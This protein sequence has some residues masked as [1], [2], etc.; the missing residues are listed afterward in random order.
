MMQQVSST[1]FLVFALM[2][3]TRGEL[4]FSTEIMDCDIIFTWTGAST[5]I[6]EVFINQYDGKQDWIII[7]NSSIRVK[8]ALLYTSIIMSV[9]VYKGKL[10]DS[11][12]NDNTLNYNVQPVQPVIKGNIDI[13]VGTNSKLTCFVPACLSREASLSY[14]W[15]INDTKMKEETTEMLTFPVTRDHKYNQYSCK[16]ANNGVESNRSNPVTINTLCELQFS[17]EIMDCDIIFTWT[18]A[19]TN[20]TEVFIN[21]YDGKQDWIIINNSSI[22]VKNALLY[23]SIIMSVRVYK[24]KLRDSSFN[25]N[26][27]NYNVQPVQPVIKGNIDILVGTNS[28]LTCFVPAC[29]SREASLSYTWFINDTKMKEETTE[30]LTF[31][32]TRDHKYNQYSC[33]V[34]NNGVES[35]RSN[36]VTI[37][38]LSNL[39]SEIVTPFLNEN[40]ILMGASIISGILVMTLATVAG[41]YFIKRGRR[42]KN[43]ESVKVE[44]VVDESLHP[45]HPTSALYATIDRKS[46]KKNYNIDETVNTEKDVNVK[47]ESQLPFTSFGKEEREKKDS[48]ENEEGNAIPSAKTDEKSVSSNLKQEGLIYIEVDFANKPGSTD[49]NVQPM[50][51]GQEDPTEYTFVDFSQKAPPEQDKPENVEQK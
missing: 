36:P 45:E 32:V 12:F 35:N 4:Q 6:T 49:T 38:T 20:I 14:T 17:T 31:P 22:R 3:T 44:A 16:V 42:E 41:L 26:T 50:I 30:M 2:C 47:D 39:K 19:S 37:N 9:R 13:L 33:K 46:L 43:Q 23:T 15:F 27:L 8:N 34:A 51:R 1:L 48:E 11:S 7:N 29:L 5:N 28:K 24:G 10:R 18:G 21:Q 25:D 40:I